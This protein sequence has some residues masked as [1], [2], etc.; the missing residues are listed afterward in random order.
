MSHA[1]A[2]VEIAKIANFYNKHVLGRSYKIYIL[3]ARLVPVWA[4]CQVALFQY[5]GP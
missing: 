4:C 3:V 2:R 1:H 5:V